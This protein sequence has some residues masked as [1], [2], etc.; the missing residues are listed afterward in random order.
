MNSKFWKKYKKA[1]ERFGSQRK[2][3]N[4]LKV[5]RSTLQ[6]WLRD[7]QQAD[8]DVPNLPTF[9]V[10]R[11]DTPIYVNPDGKIKRFIFVAVQDQSQ[12]HGVF[13]KNL[14]IY[15]HFMNAEIVAGGFTYNKSLFE[16]HNKNKSWYHPSIEKYLTNRQFIF[17]EHLTFCGEMNTLPTAVNPLSGF[18]TYTRH[19]SGIF[20]H[21]KVRLESIPT[22][23]GSPTKIN[24]TTGAITLPNYVPKRAGITASFHHVIGAVIVEIHPERDDIWFARHIQAEN[25]G[26]FQDLDN[27]VTEDG[28]IIVSMDVEAVNWGDIHHPRYDSQVID[29]AFGRG[30][31]L[32]SLNPSYQFLH[33]LT[34]FDLRSHHT[35]KDPYKRFANWF[36][37]ENMTIKESFENIGHFLN[38]EVFRDYC[39]TVVVESNHDRHFL[40]WLK[41][42]DWRDDPENAE[43]YL[44]ANLHYIREIKKANDPNMF[45]W[46]IK[47]SY[48]KGVNVLDPSI[49]FLKEDESFV[50]CATEEDTGIECGM[51][52]HLGANGAKAHPKQFTK[53]GPK[54]NTGH[55]HSASI[56]DGIYTA[57]TSS[58][59]NM[60]YNR[61]LSSWTHTHIVTYKSGKR[62]LITMKDGLWRIL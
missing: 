2:A 43:L 28:K 24:M 6:G 52:G 53:M 12:I 49:I 39:Q 7:K 3:A 45:E 56:I 27:Y 59:L 51:H 35:M 20:P 18:E 29:A 25:N 5:P 36:W 10:M 31:M 13:L 40:R 47:N 34:D 44:E 15:A 9:N 54:A 62:A 33:D 58:N 17:G 50:I 38:E 4:Y 42:A 11:K 61:G 14:E 1:L 37:S 46:G 16:D 8:T 55:T 22:M 19:R 48:N 57:G 23:K 60:G 30:G 26:A 21:A 32:D 41:E